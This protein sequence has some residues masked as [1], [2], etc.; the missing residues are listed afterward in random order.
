MGEIK[1]S[2]I[3]TEMPLRIPLLWSNGTPLES[4]KRTAFLLLGIL[5]ASVKTKKG[6]AG[7]VV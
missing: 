3:G 4:K 1:T 5:M 2:S 7:T 6:A